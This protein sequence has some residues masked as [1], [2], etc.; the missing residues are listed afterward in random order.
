M[1]NAIYLT[2]ASPA[3]VVASVNLANGALTL[4]QTQL[5]HARNLTITV[6]DAD[7]SISAGTV[8]IVGTGI[9]GSALSEV[10]TIPVDGTA[11]VTGT[12]EF[13]TI[14]SATVASLAGAVAGDTITVGE[15]NTY[16]IETDHVILDSITI[17]ETSAGAITVIDGTSGTT[18]NVA[19]LKAS[20]A[21]QTFCFDIDCWEGLRV[22]MAGASKI[23]IVTK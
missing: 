8:T 1:A 9:D 5:E 13:K 17:G 22:I 4:L 18:A 10:F 2:G 3:S 7:G 16:Q 21:E 14:T 12:A 11:T 19:T 6:T 15:G 23:T 20:I